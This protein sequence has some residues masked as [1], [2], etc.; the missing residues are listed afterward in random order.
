MM[1]APKSSGTTA[2]RSVDRSLPRSL[3][4]VA[5]TTLVGLGGCARPEQEV[6]APSLETLTVIPT[7]LGIPDNAADLPGEHPIDTTRTTGRFPAGLSIAKVTAQL[8]SNGTDRRLRPGDMPFE[9]AA[10]WNQVMDILPPIREVTQLRELGID[11][12]GAEYAD[13]LR[14]SSNI[15]CN[16]CLLYGRSKDANGEDNLVA[17]L[18]DARRNKAISA[19]RVPIVV[20]PALIEDE[21][22][23]DDLR[24]AYQTAEAQ[25]ELD[26]RNMVRNS[27]WGLVEI[28]AADTTT[29]PSPWRNED[30]LYPRDQNPF[31]RLEDL[32]RKS[33]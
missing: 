15:N 18:W 10:Y 17:A 23:E 26:L 28:D 6:T 2:Q 11:P 29:Q 20:D 8:A 4:A 19:Y 27:L 16:L 24:F 13:F 32:L 31:R 22:D 1:R 30:T 14:E 5:F 3:L 21:D 33:K 25:A 12:R 9:R 7:D